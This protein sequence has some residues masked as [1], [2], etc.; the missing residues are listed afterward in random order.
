MMVKYDSMP[1]TGTEILVSV[2]GTLEGNEKFFEVPHSIVKLIV[3][4]FKVLS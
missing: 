4:L 1:L 2:E 3:S